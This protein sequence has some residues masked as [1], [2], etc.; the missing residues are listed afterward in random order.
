VALLQP[1]GRTRR[2]VV[3][4]AQAQQGLLPLQRLRRPQGV[5]GELRPPPLQG[6]RQQL[7]D[8]SDPRARLPAQPPC[9]ALRARPQAEGGPQALGVP[10]H[11]LLVLG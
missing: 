4:R 1:Q 8:L 6:A 5:S 9:T 3:P 11:G 7:R 2:E 10:G